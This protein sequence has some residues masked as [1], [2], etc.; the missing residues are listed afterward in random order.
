MCGCLS[1]APPTRDL[2]CNPDMCPDWESNRRPFYSQASTQ[3]TEPH[4]LGLFAHL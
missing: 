1:Y 2:A 3:F 4:Q